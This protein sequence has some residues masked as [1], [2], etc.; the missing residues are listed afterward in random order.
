MP[1]PPTSRDVSVSVVVPCYNV[2][3]YVER[4]VASALA[5]TAPPADVVCVDDGSTDGTLGVLRR[6]ERAHPERVRVLAGP[7]GGAPAARNRGLAEARGVYVQ[8]LDADDE[9]GPDKLAGQVA[10]AE[11]AGADLVVGAYHHVLLDGSERAARPGG[12][13]PWLDL[14]EQRLGIT[15]S[16]LWRRAAVEAVGGWDAAWPSSQEVELAFRLLKAGAVVA[17]DDA[18]RT[19]VHA[20]EGSISNEFSGP[21]RERFVRVRADALAYG[22]AHGLLSGAALADA[23]E[24]VFKAVRGLY[25]YD[26][27]AARTYY[28]TAL[29][30]RYV[31]PVSAF[32]TRPYVL[33]L[34]LLGF[35]LA[36][37]LRAA[38]RG[39]VSAA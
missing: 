29:P 16:N 26:R 35:D 37:R 10:V 20:R 34:R 3:R 38:G 30:R 27:T 25:G 5:Q 24:A 9:I 36:E 31:P 19:A 28:R 21:N 8:F 2:E 32:N 7:N 11:R 23:R 14:L 12:R 33:A 6:L 13:G 4:A 15:S 1:A 17:Y 18:D 39:G 22:E